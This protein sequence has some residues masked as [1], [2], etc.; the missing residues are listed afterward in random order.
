VSRPARLGPFS[1]TSTGAVSLTGKGRLLRALAGLTPARD[2]LA[3]LVGAVIATTPYAVVVP[4]APRLL[5]WPNQ[6][7]LTPYNLFNNPRV[8]FD[9]GVDTAL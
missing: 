8:E 6:L 9:T 1:T 2:R 3:T 5:G 7:S 4:G